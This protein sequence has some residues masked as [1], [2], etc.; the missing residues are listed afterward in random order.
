[1]SDEESKTEGTTEFKSTPI[2]EVKLTESS[3]VRVSTFDGRDGRKRVDIR[4]FL[5]GPK[6]TGPTKRGVSIPVD[7]LPELEKLL[8]QT[9]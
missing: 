9:H 3:T 5:S 7:Q 2:G 1:M 6:Y 8:S 4:L